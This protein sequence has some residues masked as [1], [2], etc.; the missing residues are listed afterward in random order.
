MPYFDESPPNSRWS[1][2]NADFTINEKGRAINEVNKKLLSGPGHIAAASKPVREGV[3]VY[4]PRSSFYT[5]TLAHMKKQLT[6]DPSADMTKLTGLGP[7]ME[8]L[9]NS[10]V[11]LLR[12]L[13]FQYEFGD[14]FDLTAERLSKTRIVLLSHVIC[15]GEEHLKLL[16][17]FVKNGGVIIAESGTA[18]RNID[19][20]AYTTTPELFKEIF[21]V[22][23]KSTNLSPIV[24]SDNVT[25]CSAVRLNTDSTN[26]V[27]RN[28]KAFYLDF[29]ISPDVQGLKVLSNI[30]ELSGVKP[31]YYISSNPWTTAP[32]VSLVA[33]KLGD[34]T[35]LFVTGDSESKS[36]FTIDLP[37]ATNVYEIT[38]GNSL[39][40]ASK[41]SDELS[42]G[43]ARVYAL[44]ESVPE[45]L[46]ASADNSSYKPGNFVTLNFDCGKNSGGRLIKID[47]VGR[48]DAIVPAIPDIARLQNG[49]GKV[50]FK[51]P[52]N[53]K[54]GIIQLKVTDIASGRKAAISL[55][56]GS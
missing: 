20:R 39:G 22:E 12:A 9:P 10:F 7:W 8:Q 43:E 46:K 54:K 49:K 4:Y 41:I 51:I 16:R 47:T 24:E 6:A 17:D 26:P 44:A 5:N 18:R 14:E 29:P 21:G 32:A 56:V 48:K 25:S 30:A 31:T 50:S 15:L 19:G 23:R 36:Q 55:K 27:Y 38:E 52:L 35:Y 2:F 45:Q 11:P 28:G 34:I 13:G 33:R 1:Y 37:K 40:H 53:S 3:F 42:Y